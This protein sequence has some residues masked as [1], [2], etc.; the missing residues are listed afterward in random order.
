MTD[1]LID[2][3]GFV[4]E[5]VDNLIKIS[6][7]RYVCSQCGINAVIQKPESVQFMIDSSSK[8]FYATIHSFA[9]G[10]GFTEKYGSRIKFVSGKE[11]YLLYKTE[12]MSELGDIMGLVS[13]ISQFYHCKK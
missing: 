9:K 2:R 8:A 1:E 12:K 10:S 11:P 3:Y 5:N 6:R 13:Q 7:I 4:P